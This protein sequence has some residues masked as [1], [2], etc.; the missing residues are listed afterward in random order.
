[1]AIPESIMC[2]GGVWDSS[3]VVEVEKETP[4]SLFFPIRDLV[5]SAREDGR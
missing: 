2:E 4:S 3:S 5:A 1:M